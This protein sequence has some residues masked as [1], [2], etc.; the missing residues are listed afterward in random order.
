[1]KYIFLLFGLITFDS[2]AQQYCCQNP[3]VAFDGYDI[4]SYYTGE[5]IQ[6]GSKDIFYEYKGM[7]LLFKN[8]VNRNLFIEN[9]EKYFPEYGAW[10]AIAMSLGGLVKPNYN[11]YILQEDNKLLFFTIQ[12]Y[13][14]GITLW[15]KDPKGNKIK[16][17]TYYQT[18]Y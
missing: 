7:T 1:M 14:N 9:P 11:Y 3:E 17:D 18:V 4:T 2:Y 8:E 10:C 15:Q 16:A 5:G 12:G 6:S 13:V